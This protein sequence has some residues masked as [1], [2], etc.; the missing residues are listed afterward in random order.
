MRQIR[1]PAEDR[2]SVKAPK[3]KLRD[4][5]DMPGAWLPIAGR[6]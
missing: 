6:I 3:V 4:D 2:D 1:K 5:F